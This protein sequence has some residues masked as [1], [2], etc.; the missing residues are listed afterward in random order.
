MY[1]HTAAIAQFVFNQWNLRM[2]ASWRA[3]TRSMASVWTAKNFA[4]YA[5]LQQQQCGNSAFEVANEKAFRS[6][7]IFSF[8]KGREEMRLS[9][10]RVKTRFHAACMSFFFQRCEEA[11]PRT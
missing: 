5:V 1:Q 4:P 8:I 2:H 3:I 7:G 9:Q 6:A 10:A 11:S